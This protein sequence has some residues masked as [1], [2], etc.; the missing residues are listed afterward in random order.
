MSTRQQPT[1]A[2]PDDLSRTRPVAGAQR[3][4]ARGA[5]MLGSLRARTVAAHR[6]RAVRALGW[7]RARY[8]RVVPRLARRLIAFDAAGTLS[9]L[10]WVRRRRHGVPPGVVAVPYVAA[11]FGLLVTFAV[12]TAVELVGIELLLRALGAPGPVRAALLVLDGYGVLAVLGILAGCVT[13]PHVVTA[14][15]VRIR[16]AGLFDLRIPRSLVAQAKRIRRYDEHG[17]VRIVDGQLSVA[18]AA[19]TNVELTLAEPVPATRPLG[20]VE[21]VRSVRLYADDPAAALAAL[22]PPT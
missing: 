21:P 17:M 1:G 13:R 14:D 3:G 9:L 22:A 4:R 8:E 19:Q 7:L 6:A 11:Q 10:L 12:L 2:R 5:R 20:R 15:E 18:V 16:Y